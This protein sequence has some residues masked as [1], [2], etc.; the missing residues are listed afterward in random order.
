MVKKQT[1]FWLCVLLI[2]PMFVSANATSIAL[3]PAEHYIAYPGQTVQQHIDVTYS[4]TSG[5]TLKLDLETQ[6]LSHVSGNGQEIVFDDGE[7]QRFIWTMTLPQATQLGTDTLRINIIDTSD[8]SNQSV[9]VGLKVTGPS[10]FRFGNTQT[11]SFVVDPGIRTNVATNITSNATLDDQITF[12]VQTDSN[13]N[14]GWTMSESSGPTSSLTLTP[15]TMDFVRIWVDVPEVIDGAPLA[16]QGPTFRLIGTSGLDYVNIAWDFTLE[17]SE[18]RNATID[19]VQ[20][21]LTVAPDANTRVD[22]L[23]RNNGNAPDTI[24][25]TLGNVVIN[26]QAIQEDNADRISA[27]GWTVALFN[28]FEDV[29]LMP[30][31]S[32]VVEIGVQSPALTSGT[33]SVDLVLHP[34]NFPF[35]TVRQTATVDIAWD[36]DVEVSLVPVDCT[37]LQPNATCTGMID[38]RNVGNFADSIVVEPVSAPEF[39]TDVSSQDSAFQLQRY[40]E[41]SFQAIQ[42]NI[43]EN[44]TAY[45]QGSIE[46]DVRLNNGP[47][48]ERF[49]IQTIVAPNVAWTFLDGSNE[50]DSRGVVSFAVQL[51]NDGNLEDGLIVQLQSSHS[52]NSGFALPEGAITEGDA[53]PPRTFE[54]RDLPREANF[55]LRGTAELPTEQAGNGTLVLDIVVRSIFDPDTEFIFTIEENFTGKQWQTTSDEASYS[56]SEFVEDAVLIIKGWWLFFA[57]IAVAGIVLNKAVRDRIQR[58]EQD[59]L[60]KQLEE[61]PEETEEDWMEKF[62]KPST[63]PTIP[64]SPAISPEAFTKAFQ[65]QSNPSVPAMTPL[66]EPIR[67]A[68]T[69][70]LDHHDIASQRAT[71][72][73]IASDI[74][75]QGVSQPHQDNQNLEPSH[76]VTDRTIRHENPDLEP[77]PEMV[78]NVPL[79]SKTTIV[80]DDFD[81]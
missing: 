35:R 21:N 41:T 37:Y 46:F 50:V 23:V 78:E 70:V 44:A 34:T 24:A 20:S 56:F 64:E 74:V 17:V 18:F 47:L 75:T 1:A 32:R 65:S 19:V 68:A 69:T 42:F 4:G 16:N 30:N 5:T 60:L 31:E 63:Q 12:S 13:W 36:R 76:A 45:Q 26:D 38:V 72:D 43:E 81:L 79:P 62:N 7:T 39:V 80:D 14:W 66:P 25:M 10:D 58:N 29:T 22:V 48:V 77:Q 59:A 28:A 67:E 15:D 71:M 54:M 3:T 27:N 9:D 52:T 49:S 57:S 6:Y 8:Q 40:E 73:A 61:K 11:S 33:I 53:D 55:T 2:L 51:R